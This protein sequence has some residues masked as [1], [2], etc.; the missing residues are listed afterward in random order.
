MTSTSRATCKELVNGL[1]HYISLPYNGE[2]RL[3]LEARESLAAGIGD[4]V[5]VCRGQCRAQVDWCAQ[6]MGLRRVDATSFTRD[7]DQSEEK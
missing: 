1:T 5:D 6:A 7:R 4:E 2:E 3:A